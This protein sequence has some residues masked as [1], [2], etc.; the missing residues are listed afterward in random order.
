VHRVQRKQLGYSYLKNYHIGGTLHIAHAWL[1]L[2]DE[3]RN[4]TFDNETFLSHQS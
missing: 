2:L 4:F 1:T 3:L